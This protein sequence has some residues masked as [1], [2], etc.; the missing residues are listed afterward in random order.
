MKGA[1]APLTYFTDGG[2]GGGGGP[3][4]FFGPE[5]LAKREICMYEWRRNFFGLWKKHNNKS[6]SV[7]VGYFGVHCVDIKYWSWDFFRYK[8]WTSVGPPFLPSL[9]YEWGPWDEM[10]GGGTRDVILHS[11]TI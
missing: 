4:D 2:G 3:R 1:E 5:I 6:N 11:W 7:S 10:G 9:K 8:V